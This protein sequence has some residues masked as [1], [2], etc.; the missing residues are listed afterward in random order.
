[1]PKKV[2]S[3]QKAREYILAAAETIKK[4]VGSSLGPK[5]FNT[6]YGRPFGVPSVIHDGVTI[7]KEV[8]SEDP[9][10]DEVIK[11]IRSAAAGTNDE[12][13]DGTTTAAIL[14][15]AFITEA[16][17]LIAVGHNARM[18][19]RGME[20]A[21]EDAAEYI[22]QIA[23]PLT[24][25]QV[26][27][28]ATISAQDPDI[29]EI[30]GQVF[31]KLGS[32][33]VVTVEDSNTNTTM[34]EY[35]DGMEIG[36]GFVSPFFVTDEKLGEAVIEN[37]HVVITDRVLNDMTELQG[38]FEKLQAEKISNNVVIVAG[39]VQGHV[40]ATLVLN[41]V[42]HG[43]NIMAIKAPSF[44]DHQKELLQDLAV[45]TGAR[46]ISQDAGQKLDQVTAADIGHARR[47]VATKDNTT[48]I[49][50]QGAKEDVDARVETIRAQLAK[51]TVSGFE[52]ER[53]QERLG[54]LTTGIAIINVGAPAYS[55]LQEKKEQVID[56]VSATKAALDEGIVAGGETALLKAALTLGDHEPSDDVTA[57]YHIVMKALQQPF[58][59][60]MANSGYEPIEKLSEF[61]QLYAPDDGDF[62]T[63]GID[64]MDG[65]VKNLVEAGIIDPAKVPKCALANAISVAGSLITTNNLI[66]DITKEKEPEVV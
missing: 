31:K 33:A 46:L 48:F 34:V 10:E 42:Q 57:G 13:G 37:A 28:V 45:V 30:V 43:L 50:G 17:K 24:D 56:A 53:L 4:T 62:V 11:V 61:K 8:G 47:V 39:D 49:D 23:T 19:R 36:Q 44:G 6:L 18:L 15:H 29:G 14:T 3:D 9:F 22:T 27:D 64:V 66:V 35:K 54:K 55:A 59:M 58:L 41:K 60:L 52:A 21:A 7:A 5:G 12:A 20:L 32:G 1:M 26:T 63:R 51:P 2:V 38:F 25:K 65:Q 40:L 16:H